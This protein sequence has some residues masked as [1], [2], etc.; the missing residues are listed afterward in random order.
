MKIKIL[1]I[2]T[3]LSC[4][5]GASAHAGWQY[6][7]NY[8]GDGWY[9]DD[10]S[11][12]VISVR[13][14]AALQRGS[15]NNEIG[16]AS[17][18]YFVDVNTGHLLPAGF[19][20]GGGD[21]TGYDYAGYADLADLSADKDYSNFSFAGGASIGWTI[22][23]SPQWRVE[24]G[25]DHI[26]ENKYN[27]TP[28][29][30]GEVELQGGDVTGMVIDLPSGGAQ[31]KL[32]SDIFS[33]MAFYDFFDGIRKPVKSFVP[34]VGFGLG[35][36]DSKTVLNLSDLY[37]NLMWDAD[38]QKYGEIDDNGIFQFYTSETNEANIAGL[39]AVGFSYGLTK[40]T[41][42]DFG[43]RATYIPKVTW[44]LSNEDGTR[45]RDWFSVKNLIYANVMVGVRFE[46]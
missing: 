26:A 28:L 24:L 15:I 34:Y 42:L 41:F 30:Q 32:T 25:W 17:I 4:I 31:S 13:G 39:L 12:F 37:G 11:R 3:V 10:G 27:A 45:H 44:S 7:G 8:L 22:P 19:C 35:Y 6:P 33:V 38:L 36:A 23:D 9:Q 29:F 20:D 46:F 21:C 2:F 40:T 5:C 18:E 16:T 14:G 43:V 1:S